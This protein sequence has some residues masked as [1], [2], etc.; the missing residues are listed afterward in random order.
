MK[1]NNPYVVGHAKLARVKTPAATRTWN[2]IPHHELF[3]LFANSL[4]KKGLDLVD[5]KHTLSHQGKRYFGVI[6]VK[7]K[8]EAADFHLSVGI[9]NSHDKFLAAGGVAG[10]RVI[11]CSNLMFDGEWKF[12][13]RHTSQVETRIDEQVTVVVDKLMSN[14]AVQDDRFAQY[15]A[16]ELSDPQANNLI[17]QAIDAGVI[18]A[19]DIPHVIKQ[20]RTPDHPEFSADGKTAW[21]LFNAFT[22]FFK[23]VNLFDLPKRGKALNEL[24]DSAVR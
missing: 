7:R 24:M 14:Y 9:R 13:E 15:K 16:F 23:G 8:N 11:V 22:D 21:R 2:P 18:A 6:N 3:E 12:T 19:R 1:D 5:A 4:N 20:W 17:I 10:S